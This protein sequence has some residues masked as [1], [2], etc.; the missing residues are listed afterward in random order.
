MISLGRNQGE[1]GG[2]W[3]APFAPS[4]SNVQPSGPPV[5]PTVAAGSKAG[6][7]AVR[8]N[9]GHSGAVL[10]A[11]HIPTNPG[12]ATLLFS[13]AHEVLYGVGSNQRLTK[14]RGATG[15]GYPSCSGAVAVPADPDARVG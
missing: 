12:N 2:V 3:L 4:V 10:T 14:Y 6:M 13:L 15:N 1:T 8:I 7:C 9:V 11:R 5:N